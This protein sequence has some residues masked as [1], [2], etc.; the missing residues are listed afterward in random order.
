MLLL[1]VIAILCF[2]VNAQKATKSLVLPTPT[3][4]PQIPPPGNIVLLPDYVHVRKRGI[5][6]SVGEISKPGGMVITYDIG[7]LAAGYLGRAYQRNKDNLS[8]YRWQTVNGLTLKL[9]RTKSGE[10]LATFAEPCAN[11]MTI[12]KSE[13]DFVDF[14]LMILTYKP[15]KD[16]QAAIGP[17][18]HTVC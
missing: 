12:A 3:P 2:G 6:T 13:E 9:I 8:V 15:S 4:T 10:T 5:D 18:P 11:F 1:F 16:F 7:F 14:L 17:K